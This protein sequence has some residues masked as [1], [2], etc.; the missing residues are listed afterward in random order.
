MHAKAA[1]AFM[2]RFYTEVVTGRFV[3][4]A[5]SMNHKFGVLSLELPSSKGDIELDGWMVPFSCEEAK[6]FPS[7]MLDCPG[8]L[9]VE[10]ESGKRL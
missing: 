9:E 10:E 6:T 2:E 4:G 5:D 8:E 3:S 1:P 7:I